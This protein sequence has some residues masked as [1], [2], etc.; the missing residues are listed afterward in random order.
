LDAGARRW[1]YR[2]ASGVRLEAWTDG[3]RAQSAGG[4]LPRAGQEPRLALQPQRPRRGRR[5]QVSLSAK[6]APRD[7][8]APAGRV[9][10]A[11]TAGRR[12]VAPFRGALPA[13]S[14]RVPHPCHRRSHSR[15]S[16]LPSA[17]TGDAPLLPQDRR[18]SERDLAMAQC[19][20]AGAVGAHAGGGRQRGLMA[21]SNAD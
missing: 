19:R 9:R 18:A 21:R 1:R 14:G 17:D 7:V 2:S 5:R 12:S 3:G 15:P 8:A 4:V 20:S 10:S 16:S 13:A 6:Q 11:G